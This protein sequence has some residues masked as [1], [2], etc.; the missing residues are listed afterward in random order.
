MDDL[1]FRSAA[2]EEINRLLGY[3]DEDML[4]FSNILQRPP[5]AQ[6]WIPVR[7]PPE[8]DDDYLC[9]LT[10]YGNPKSRYNAV[11]HYDAED[12]FCENGIYTNRVTHWMP[13]PE[14]PKEEP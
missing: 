3:L 14:P 10:V 1:I 2:T 6:R 5:A 9:C 4:R 13:L 11:C 12:G 7:E 8:K